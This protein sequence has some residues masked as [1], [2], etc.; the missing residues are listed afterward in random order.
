M[1]RG[2]PPCDF[3]IKLLLRGG[4]I[5]KKEEKRQNATEREREKKNVGEYARNGGRRGNKYETEARH[6]KKG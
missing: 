3:L 1:P 5:T 2:S 6:T 4:Q